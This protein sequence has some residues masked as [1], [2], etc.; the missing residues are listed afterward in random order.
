M[1]AAR[2]PSSSGDAKG[3]KLLSALSGGGGDDGFSAV[4]SA[5]GVEKVSCRRNSRLAD[6]GAQARAGGRASCACW[7]GGGG[8]A[9]LQAA[10]G[11]AFRVTVSEAVGYQA[12]HDSLFGTSGPSALYV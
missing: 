4:L 7:P 2:R 10:G 11:G 12:H 6:L 9:A 1:L 8:S 5:D 3:A